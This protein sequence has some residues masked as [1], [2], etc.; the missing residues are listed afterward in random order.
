MRNLAEV[1]PMNRADLALRLRHQV[2]RPPGTALH[3]PRI[4]VQAQS[5]VASTFAV[6]K[7][8]GRKGDGRSLFLVCGN[9]SH[10]HVYNVLVKSPPVPS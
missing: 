8:G 10:G 9:E 1:A 7:K 2:R 3:F 4:F 5:I 6:F